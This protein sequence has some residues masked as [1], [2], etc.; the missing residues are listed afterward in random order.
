MD[1]EET[2]KRT[3][4][5]T[6]IAYIRE[7]LDICRGWYPTTPVQASD[8]KTRWVAAPGSVERLLPSCL[9]QLNL[10]SGHAY[11]YLPD[12]VSDEEVN[13]FKSPYQPFDARKL[14]PMP[15]GDAYYPVEVPM[16]VRAAMVMLIRRHLIS[17]PRACCIA[18]EQCESRDGALPKGNW[19]AV[20][21]PFFVRRPAYAEVYSCIYAA[22]ANEETLFQVLQ[23]GS[24]WQDIALTRMPLEMERI[25]PSTMLGEQQMLA[26]AA[27]TGTIITRAYHMEGWI[28]WSRT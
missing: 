25:E 24:F 5:P 27:N 26:I 21:R 10:D 11:T 19:S 8:G 13:A 28:V 22:D 12:Y 9:L 1:A 6:A 3:L 20:P 23:S 14:H 16:A 15:S 2:H 17:D 4:G 18:D 7:C